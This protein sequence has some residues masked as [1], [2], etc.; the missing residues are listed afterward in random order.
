MNCNINKKLWCTTKETKKKQDNDNSNANVKN[1]NY[2]V[3]YIIN[4]R[5]FCSFSLI[6]HFNSVLSSPVVWQYFSGFLA[7]SFILSVA[8][9]LLSELKQKKKHTHR[10]QC[11]GT[12]ERYETED[13]TIKYANLTRQF[14]MT[15]SF[16]SCRTEPSSIPENRKRNELSLA[17]LRRH[18]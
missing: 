3:W 1:L 16:A 8:V 18:R 6:R 15:F 13:W 11:N 12:H 9:V 7:R 14:R 10:T 2:I 17:K 4:A 5:N